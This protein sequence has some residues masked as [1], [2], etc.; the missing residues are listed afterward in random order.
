VDGNRKFQ[1]PKIRNPKKQK[2]KSQTKF[3]R[4]TFIYHSMLIL[5]IPTSFIFTGMNRAESTIFAAQKTIR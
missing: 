4:Q 5:N 3:Q 2:N 1:V